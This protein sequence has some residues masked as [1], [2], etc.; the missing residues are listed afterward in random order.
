M[1]ALNRFSIVREAARGAFARIVTSAGPAVLPYIPTLIHAL[2]HQVTEAE[3]VDL[4]NFFGLITHKYKDNV[5]SVM[6]D[7]FGVLVTRIFSFLNQGIQGTD[8]MVRRSDTERAYFGLVHALL[9]AGLDD[10][11]VSE[12]N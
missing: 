12:K 8:D 4:L 9:S 6:D 1:T 5:R 7:V 3:L 2:V 11:L 10:V